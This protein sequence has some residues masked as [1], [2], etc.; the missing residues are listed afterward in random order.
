MN[1]GDNDDGYTEVLDFAAITAGNASF[2]MILVAVFKVSS[3][4][5]ILS[6]SDLDNWSPHVFT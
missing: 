2:I 6:A 3:S 5:F 1:V 4:F